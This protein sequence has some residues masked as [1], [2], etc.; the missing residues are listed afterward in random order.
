MNYLKTFSKALLLFLIILICSIIIIT[1]INYFNIISDKTSKILLLIVTIIS[2][3]ISSFKLGKN[4]SHKGLIE[5]LKFGLI[6]SLSFIIISLLLKYN[7]KISNYLYYIII[8]ISSI[9]GSI[10]GKNRRKI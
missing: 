10:I 4:T 6:I 1:L 3:I 8:I 9:F 2:I 7:Y 5:G